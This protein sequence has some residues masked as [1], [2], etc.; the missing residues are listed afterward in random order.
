MGVEFLAM[1]A[2]SP[3]PGLL[4]NRLLPLRIASSLARVLP[5]VF[6]PAMVLYI[7]QSAAYLPAWRAIYIGSYAPKSVLPN[8]QMWYRLGFW[9]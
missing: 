9:G 6:L 5:I 1:H 4:H 8:G 7:P 2:F 3:H